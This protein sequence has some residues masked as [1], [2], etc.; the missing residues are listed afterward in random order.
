MHLLLGAHPDG[1][2]VNDLQRRLG[3]PASTLSHHLERLKSRNLVTVRREHKCLRYTANTDT[4]QE[5]LAFLYA[6]CCSGSR[7]VASGA[8]GQILKDSGTPL[9]RP[10]PVRN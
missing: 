7:A 1:M 5:L 6:E 8:I 2:V 10:T 4:L 9:T 3:I